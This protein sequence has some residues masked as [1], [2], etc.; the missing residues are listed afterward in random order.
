[1]VNHRDKHH[2]RDILKES[3]SSVHLYIPSSAALRSRRAVHVKRR[4]L[5]SSPLR[6]LN[7]RYSD[8]SVLTNLDSK[9]LV[10]DLVVLSV[11]TS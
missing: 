10:T 6:G 4:Y 2:I 11:T 7:L 3:T 5:W 9:R 1:M 8:C